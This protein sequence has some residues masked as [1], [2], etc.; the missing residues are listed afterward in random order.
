MKNQKVKKEFDGRIFRFPLKI[1]MFFVTFLIIFQLHR[2]I[3]FSIFA[4]GKGVGFMGAVSAAWHGLPMDWSM[5][6]YCTL[7]PFL[8]LLI[9]LWF[10]PGIMNRILK[11]YFILISIFLGICLVAD[12]ILFSYWNFRLNSNPV[13]YFFSSP[14][15]ALASANKWELFIGLLLIIALS[16]I[17]FLVL[18][19]IN[20]RYKMLY[21]PAVIPSGICS[22]V[23]AV[24]LFI[25][26]RGGLTVSTMNIS[27]AYYSE[28]EY[29]NQSAINPVFSLL[30]TMNHQYDFNKAQYFNRKQLDYIF[31]ELDKNSL[32]PDSLNTVHLSNLNLAK[33][34][35]D[36]FVIILE[37]F[38]NHLFPSLGGEPIAMGLDSIAS[39]SIVFDNFYATGLRTDRGIPAI[40]SGFPGT[41]D[42]SVMKFVEKA[43]HLPGIASKLKGAGYETSYYY[44]GDADFTNMKAFLYNTGYNNIISD[45]DFPLSDKI[46]KWGAPDNK[47]FEK[48]LKEYNELPKDEKPRFITIQTSSSH[49]PFDVPEQDPRFKDSPKANAFAFTDRQATNFIN[50]VSNTER[51]KNALFVIV[52]DHWAAYPDWVKDKDMFASHHI[53]LILT[54]GA[55]KGANYRISKIGSQTDVP[56]I[57]LGLK[58]IDAS[59]F[60]FS[61]NILDP[62][63]PGYAWMYRNDEIAF[64]NSRGEVIY[65][66]YT[67]KNVYKDNDIKLTDYAKAILQKIYSTLSV[68]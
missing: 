37:S 54:G 64:I 20:R 22:V 7:I 8:L 28:N 3:F 29:L 63:A 60:S 42:V 67:D 59:D 6:G 66:I 40:L 50:A 10:H 56:A 25:S 58:G 9:S 65:N 2:L 24:F 30:Y 31:S 11:F 23:L 16:G 15:A 1:I 45:K 44:G 19:T 4:S 48:V 12:P 13:F 17:I 61:K 5:A 26:I 27:N 51:G 34:N 14:G 68:L 47:L 52:A 57:L 35:P 18:R 38:S 36:I 41:P 33:E 46:S 53:P 43:S 49:E 32:T 55:L 21:K 39:S 62:K